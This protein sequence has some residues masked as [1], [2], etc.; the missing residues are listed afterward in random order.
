MPK[1]R[2]L[3]AL[4]AILACGLAHAA[5][6]TK[7]AEFVG[8]DEPFASNAIYFVM[9]DRFVN[10]DPSNDQRNQGGAHHTFDIPVPGPNGESA[11]I[12]YLG[13]DFKGVLNNAGYIHDMGFGAV[14]ITPIVQNPDEPFS[15]GDPV[16]W[17]SFW[18]D[19]GKTGYHGYWGV[20]FYKLDPH[21][22]SKNL[23][24]T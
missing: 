17:D 18:T 2:L 11:N 4:V 8:T 12:G 10:G 15:G 19:Q 21:L 9:T 5:T 24:F 6:P 3:P 16:S 1:L 20:N 14:W 7:A 22:P 13:G 23:D